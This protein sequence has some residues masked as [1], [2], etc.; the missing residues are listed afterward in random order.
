MAPGPSSEH[1]ALQG[2]AGSWILGQLP[3]G[4]GSFS[5]WGSEFVRRNEGVNVEFSFYLFLVR[6]VLENVLLYSF[7]GDQCAIHGTVP[8]FS[9]SQ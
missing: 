2:K 1:L 9:A 4:I 5:D 7:N 3:S 8:V 6:M